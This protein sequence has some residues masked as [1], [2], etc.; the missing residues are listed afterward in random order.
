MGFY[1]YYTMITVGLSV[2]ITLFL[3]LME[4]KMSYRKRSGLPSTTQK[5]EE[6]K[7]YGKRDQFKR[8]IEVELNPKVKEKTFDEIEPGSTL[9]IEN[10][11]PTYAENIKTLLKNEIQLA[12]NLQCTITFKNKEGNEENSMKVHAD[13][14][15]AVQALLQKHNTLKVKRS[16]NIEGKGRHGHLFEQVNASPSNTNFVPEDIVIN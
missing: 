4:D 12:N 15:K 8:T 1:K 9:L 6:K 13:V 3:F 5:P 10:M 7:E 16:I 2:V 11:D 14:L